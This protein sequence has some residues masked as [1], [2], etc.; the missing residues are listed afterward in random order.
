MKLTING[1]ELEY[2]V[3]EADKAELYQKETEK[4]IKVCEK[5]KDNEDL[6]KSIRIQCKAIFE[7]I[8]ALFGEGV[9]REVFGDSVNLRTCAKVYADINA[10][11]A[12]DK[13]KMLE[14]LNLTDNAAGV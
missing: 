14:L 8:D 2:D 12:A 13:E 10:A 6:A 3:Y 4:I 7:F 9:H 11:I 5:L 1:V